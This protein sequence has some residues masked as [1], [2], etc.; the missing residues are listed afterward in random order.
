MLKQT[1]AIDCCRVYGYAAGAAANS[2][3]IHVL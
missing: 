3:I 2:Q 1:E